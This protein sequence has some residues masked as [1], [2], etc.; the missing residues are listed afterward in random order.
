[1]K[2]GFFIGAI[3]GAILGVIISLSMDLVLGDALGGG[4]REAVAHDL[5]ALF[6][7]TFGNNSFVV[8]TGVVA[9]IGFIAAFGA[10]VGGIFGVMITRLFSFLTKEEG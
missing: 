5:G 10:F 9:V 4:W 3:C 2:R 6:G 8:L 1:M 7:T